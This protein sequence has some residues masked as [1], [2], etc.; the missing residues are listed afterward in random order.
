MSPRSSSAT[1]R[2]TCVPAAGVAVADAARRGGEERLA[3]VEGERDDFAFHVAGGRGELDR[4][5]FH[6]RSRGDGEGND[7]G[8]IFRDVTKRVGG[9]DRLRHARAAPREREDGERPVFIVHE[10]D[11]TP[12]GL[13]RK[14]PRPLT[15]GVRHGVGDHQ[16]SVHGELRAVVGSDV[17]SV[18]A[19]GGDAHETGDAAGETV[20]ARSDGG[21]PGGVGVGDGLRRGDGKRL[22]GVEVRHA[23]E[24][25]GGQAELGA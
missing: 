21:R 6:M 2:N 25:G 16:D 3:V 13:E 15:R 14:R 20:A 23:G 9:D 18:E 11:R 22:E 10:L 5:P 12:A 17:E 1:A 24:V 7:R 8:D 19:G 4:Q